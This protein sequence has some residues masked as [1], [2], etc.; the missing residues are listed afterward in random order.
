[1]KTFKDWNWK[2]ALERTSVNLFI[3]FVAIA[4]TG[5]LTAALYDGVGAA[6]PPLLYKTFV[7]A[8]FVT[9]VGSI[10][11][12]AVSLVVWLAFED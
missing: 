3:A 10:V 2:K 9:G 7:S 4:F 12:A 5:L 6:L 11:C 1:M 8:S